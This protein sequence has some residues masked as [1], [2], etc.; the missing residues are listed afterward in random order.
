M[1]TEW[2]Q[3]VSVRQDGVYLFSKSS[4]D[5]RPYHSWKCD[6]LTEVF[7][8][9][10][11]KGLDREM[12]RMLCEY[13]QIRGHHPSVER[14]RPCLLATGHFS[15]EYVGKLNAEYAKLTPEDLATR[16]LPDEQRSDAMRAYLQFDKA[17]RDRY[18]R[19]LAD[20]AAPQKPTRENAGNAR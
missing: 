15:P 11:Q 19:N 12:V 6:S 8:A 17:E 3:R 13:V 5:N 9:Q 4:N 2:I 16:Y 14:Y 18:Y 20:C 10:G 1:S 7:N